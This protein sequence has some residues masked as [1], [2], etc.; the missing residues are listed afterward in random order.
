MYSYTSDIILSEDGSPVEVVVLS[1]V[2][3]TNI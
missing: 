3:F 1:P 2:W